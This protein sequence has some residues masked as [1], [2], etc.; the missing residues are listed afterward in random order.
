MRMLL[1]THVFLWFVLGDAQLSS[2]AKSCILD[3]VNTKLVEHIP[4]I[5]G[6]PVLDAYMITRL[7]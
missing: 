7:W 1:D 6:D 4:I 5:S 2:M 3:P